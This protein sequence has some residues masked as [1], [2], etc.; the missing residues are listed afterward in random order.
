M[1]GLIL[2]ARE[3]VARIKQMIYSHLGEGA[4]SLFP[5]TN[6]WAP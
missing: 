1:L 4:R 5:D 2:S 3:E 6:L